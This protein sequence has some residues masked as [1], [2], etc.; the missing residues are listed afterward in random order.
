MYSCL[1]VSGFNQR[2]STVF[3]ICNSSC[4]TLKMWITGEVEN[5]CTTRSSANMY[6]IADVAGTYTGTQLI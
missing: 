6:L 3:P 4:R 1:L 5:S 2:N